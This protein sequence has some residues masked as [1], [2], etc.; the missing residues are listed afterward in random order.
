MKGDRQALHGHR[1]E[2]RGHFQWENMQRRPRQ[3]GLCWKDPKAIVEEMEEHREI[4][5]V[6]CWYDPLKFV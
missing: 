3:V 2:L 1:Q 6:I 4:R 5:S